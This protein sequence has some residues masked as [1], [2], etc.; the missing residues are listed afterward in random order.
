MINAI[1]FMLFFPVVLAVGFK[2]TGFIFGLLPSYNES[3]ELGQ[4]LQKKL[5]QGV[6]SK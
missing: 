5:M 4:T 6:K 1:M 3:K 2:L